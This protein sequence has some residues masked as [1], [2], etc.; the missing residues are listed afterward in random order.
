MAEKARY[1]HLL[2]QFLELRAVVRRYQRRRPRGETGTNSSTS[3]DLSA[4]EIIDTA[5]KIV[6]SGS[7]TWQREKYALIASLYDLRFRHLAAV[8][9]IL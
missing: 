2:E 4:S 5:F 7:P 1:L 8:F 6:I 3:T 9:T